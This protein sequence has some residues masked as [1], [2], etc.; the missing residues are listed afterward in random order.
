MALLF[1]HFI[2]FPFLGIVTNKDASQSSGH[3]HCFHILVQSFYITFTVLSPGIFNNSAGMSS[4][5]GLLLFLRLYS[6]FS[7]SANRGGGSW[8][9]ELISFGH[10]LSRFGFSYNFSQHSFHLF[11]TSKLS[12]NTLLG[13]SFTTS[14][15]G[16][17]RLVIFSTAL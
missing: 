1:S 11:N 9:M 15:L 2:I 17:K 12:V 13:S 7:T 8:I 4:Y 16:L 14:S 10:S 3:S 5:P 6:A